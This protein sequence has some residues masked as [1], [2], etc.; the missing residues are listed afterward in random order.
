VPRPGN[1][2]VRALH[3]TFGSCPRCGARREPA[4]RYC[5]EC[6]L[7]LP[8][9]EGRLPAARRAWMTHLGWYPGDFVWRALVV[10]LVAVAGGGAAIA[11]GQWRA[12]GHPGTV[13]AETPAALPVARPAGARNGETRWPA[14]ET[15]WTVVLASLPAPRG[16]R[17]GQALAARA[18]AD[19]LPQVGVLDSSLYASLQPG[20]EVVFSGVYGAPGDAASALAGVQ[21]RG[22]A[23]AYASP[24]A[25]SSS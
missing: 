2:R 11:L 25:P 7:A 4:Q 5:L 9:L 22:Y 18:A 8:L 19:G 6:G 15:G 20:Y 12:A 14:R 3:A 13:V 1:A 24:V 17:A 23:G 21:A 16:A 10:A